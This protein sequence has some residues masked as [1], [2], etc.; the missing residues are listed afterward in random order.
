MQVGEHSGPPSASQV[1]S[2][3]R[4]PIN[5]LAFSRSNIDQSRFDY[6]ASVDSDGV[7]LIWR[8]TSGQPTGGAL[9]SG[10]PA[11]S[12]R[13]AAPPPA[14]GLPQAAGGVNAAAL[15]V[16][17]S[18]DGQTIAT[19]GDDRCVCLWGLPASG[20]AGP[21]RAAGDA[22]PRCVLVG[23]GRGH[24]KA[25]LCVAVSSCLMVPAD[26]G[27]GLP[28]PFHSP[29]L[30]VSRSLAR[31]LNPLAHHLAPAPPRSLPRL[32]HRLRLAAR[33]WGG[34]PCPSHRTGPL[35]QPRRPPAFLAACMCRG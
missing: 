4:A 2:A 24:R 6:L 3:H 28:P 14:P 8:L 32:P 20:A 25:V 35:P 23:L 17:I 26:G 34:L 1:L 33:G 13:H 11:A 19:G 15:C 5:A 10:G 12:A 7:L 16:A 18:H 22:A 27:P 21:G 31:P 29:P 30:S 9:T